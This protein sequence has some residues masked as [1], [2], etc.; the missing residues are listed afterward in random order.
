MKYDSMK[1]EPLITA[2]NLPS[3]DL[4]DQINF[5]LPSVGQRWKIS[6]RAT[7]DS[8]PALRGRSISR[9]AI[10]NAA[11]EALKL[12]AVDLAIKA[13]KEDREVSREATVSLEIDRL[14]DCAVKGRDP[15][16]TGVKMLEIVAATAFAQPNCMQHA[17]RNTNMASLMNGQVMRTSPKLKQQLDTVFEVLRSFYPH[18]HSRVAT[19]TT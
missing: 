7:R 13:K 19:P 5:Y 18:R 9:S 17:I 11:V 15:S 2:A 6:R 16:K 10:Q 14:L 3:L 1:F 8:A 12:R 4:L